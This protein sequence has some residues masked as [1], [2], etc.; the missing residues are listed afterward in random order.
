MWCAARSPRACPAT[1]M[2]SYSHFCIASR[3][4]GHSNIRFSRP[5]DCLWAPHI[6]QNG[7]CH[8]FGGG[9]GVNRSSALRCPALQA[10]LLMSTCNIHPVLSAHAGRHVDPVH[11]RANEVPERLRP[12]VTLPLT[13]VSH[14]CAQTQGSNNTT[15]AGIAHACRP[16]HHHTTTTTATRIP[17]TRG[18]GDHSR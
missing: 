10:R 4:S 16:H 6:T 3:R 2:I 15:L 17:N 14:S 5:R 13:H 12:E 8:S 9:G 1:S 18:R 11:S 7:G